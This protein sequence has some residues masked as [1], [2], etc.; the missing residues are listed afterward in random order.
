MAVKAYR[1]GCQCGAVRYEVQA[2]LDSTIT[3]NCSRC[4]KLGWVLS[5]APRDQFTLTS[6]EDRLTEYLFNKRA[7]QHLFCAVCGIES[8]AFAAAPDGA[9]MAAINVNCLD[10]VEPR[11]LNSH[12][13][14]GRSK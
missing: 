7:I 4:Q 14:D 11:K 8:F 1:G 6:G 9:P 2:D 13:Y 10:D 12:A 3:C 5:F